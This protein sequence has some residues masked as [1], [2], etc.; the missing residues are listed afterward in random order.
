MISL[1]A[2][3]MF[4]FAAAAP[5]RRRILKCTLQ[6]LPPLMRLIPHCSNK[7]RISSSLALTF[8]VDLQSARLLLYQPAHEIKR[9][10]LTVKPKAIRNSNT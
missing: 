10:I 9:R 1:S 8:Q 5:L 7:I 4:C 2:W 3:L 6:W